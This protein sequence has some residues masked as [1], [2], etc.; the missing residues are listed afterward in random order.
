MLCSYSSKTFGVTA[1]LLAMTCLIAVPPASAEV[2]KMMKICDGKLCPV[3][4]PQLSVPQGWTVDTAAS[5]KMDV[6]VLVPRGYD[7]ARAEAVIYARAFHNHKKD[8]VD[9]RVA[10]SNRDWMAKVKGAR[11]TPLGTV[12]GSKP[13]IQFQVFEYINPGQAHQAAEIVAFG[14]DTDK[15]GNLYG[16]QVVLTALSEEALSRNKGNLLGILEDY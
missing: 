10:E 6:I 15:E 3:F 1:F 13:G 7:Y 16:V 12:A 5:S 14:E 2:R 4:L 9:K 11:I 8:T